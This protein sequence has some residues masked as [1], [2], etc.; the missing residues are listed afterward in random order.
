MTLGTGAYAYGKLGLA[1]TLG[2]VAVTSSY[3]ESSSALGYDSAGA[4]M[5]TFGAYAFG[6]TPFGRIYMASANFYFSHLG[7]LSGFRP[8]EKGE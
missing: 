2:W 4:A 6:A 3:A 7:V 8:G 5:T 1:N